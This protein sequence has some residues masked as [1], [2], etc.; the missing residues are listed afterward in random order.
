MKFGRKTICLLLVCV[1]LASVFITADAVDVDE[2]ARNRYNVVFVTDESGSMKWTDPDV[3]RYEAIRRF[4]ALMAQKGNSLGSV[5]FDDAIVDTN[6]LAPITGFA[7]KEAFIQDLLQH[8][9]SGDTNI[10]L[11]LLEAVKLLD[12]GKNPENP[13]VI[14]LLSDGNTDLKPKEAME[15]S[16]EQKAEAIELARQAGYQIYTISLNTDGSAD[17]SELAQIASATGGEFQE[18]T[19][20][21]DLEE[22]QT[23]YYKM[24]FGAVEGADAEDIEINSEGYAEKEFEVP[25]IGVEE[26]NVLLEGDVSSYSLTNAQGYT[27][28]DAELTAMTMSGDSFVVIKVEEPMGGMWK[29][30]VHGDP[31]TNINFRLLYNSDFYITTS[32][33]PK[34]DYKLEQTVTFGAT[35]CDRSGPIS[36]QSRYDG[37]SA[38][39]HL[40]VNGTKQEYDMELRDGGFFY[41]VKLTEQ[42]TYFAY[43]TA[44][45]GE[46]SA[47]SDKTYELNVNNSA[48][49][50]TDKALTGHA[51]IWPLIGGSATVDLSGA[52]TDPNGDVLV[53][54]VDST[55][56]MPEDYTLEGDTLTVH[57][58]SISKGSFTIRA[59]DP[60]GAYC[61]VE[62]S[63]TSTNIG[64]IMAILVVL[65][66]LITLVALAWGAYKLAGTPFMGT[67]TVESHDMENSGY[68]VPATITPGRG[69]IRIE[70]F[71]LG[72]CGLP[73]GSY[74]QAG[75]KK[76]VI[77]F[78]SKK[79]VYSDAV[80]GA[81]KKVTIDGNGLEVL[82]CSGVTMEKGI[83][84]SFQ[85]ILN[86]Q[87]DY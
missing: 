69:K 36:E 49:V 8:K 78:V 86:N 54:S 60:Y 14:I 51:N 30:V 16:L 24:I 9:P 45:N 81:V 31:G 18:V 68:T 76:K 58:F 50:A 59:T 15:K 20:P 28:T 83:R 34:N 57:N 84:V 73:A 35:I 77:Y 26:F 65:G 67:I 12:E 70:A 25:G 19:S 22:I 87:F 53:Y 17:N 56:Y 4:V 39:L 48:P 41:D 82:I 7:E 38:K 71:G 11:A 1:M 66:A 72:N 55:A 47:T 85:S 46:C 32:I 29:V 74:F 13:S 3:L 5:T 33:T 27:Y 63:V 6:S 2:G 40:T 62:A 21:E 64:V 42:G 75:G 44:T 10:G 80:A 23:M 61:T 37:F 52:A 43:M 79:P